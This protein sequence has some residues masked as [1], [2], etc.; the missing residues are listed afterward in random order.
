MTE[1]NRTTPENIVSLEEN[2]VFVFG[3]NLAGI[4]GGGAAYTALQWGAVIGQGTGI[5]G[6]TYAIP[7]KDETI[8]TLPIESIEPHVKEF[9]VFAKQNTEKTFLVTAVGCG[10]AGLT[11][12]QIA[13]L[14]QDAISIENIW[15]PKS[16]WKLLL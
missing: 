1:I 16:F 13:P 11:P 10:L 6:A 3:S 4:H 5:Q 12:E 8:V 14:F 15:L 2:Q 9:I 7:T